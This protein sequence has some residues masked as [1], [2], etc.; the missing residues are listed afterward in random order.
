MY[1]IGLI[2]VA[3]MAITNVLCFVILKDWIKEIDEMLRDIYRVTIKRRTI[4]EIAERAAREG[5]E[6]FPCDCD[7]EEEKKEE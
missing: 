6:L 4:Q 1:E 7:K 3:L 5:R 2:A